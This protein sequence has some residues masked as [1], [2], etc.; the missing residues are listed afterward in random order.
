[1]PGQRLK[2]AL[3][4]EPSKPMP[5]IPRQPMLPPRQPG[6][7]VVQAPV[8]RPGSY[9]MPNPIQPPQGYMPGQPLVPPQPQNYMA[10][11]EPIINRNPFGQSA[12]PPLMYEQ[13][14][15]QGQM[16]QPQQQAPQ[17]P[18][19]QYQPQPFNPYRR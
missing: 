13:Y 6:P 14:Q 10:P 1:M 2:T 4:R 16:D 7:P 3:G 18:F 12:Q 15:Q 19:P 5:Q 8:A 17:Q 9:D 11:F